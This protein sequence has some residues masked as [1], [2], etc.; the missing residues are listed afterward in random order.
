M[1]IDIGSSTTDFTLMNNLIVEDLPEFGKDFG[2][3]KIDEAIVEFIIDKSNNGEYFDE[4]SQKV[5]SQFGYLTLLCRKYKEK[6]FGKNVQI[7]VP[8]EDDLRVIYQKYSQILEKIDSEQI[9]GLSITDAGDTWGD[10]FRAL[11]V[12]V[13]N[14][15]IYEPD[16]VVVTGGGS[17]MPFVVDIVRDVFEASYIPDSTNFKFSDPSLT[18]TNGLA[19]YGRWQFNIIQFYRDVELFCESSDLDECIKAGLQPFTEALSKVYVENLHKE[20][21][22]PLLIELRDKKV[23]TSKIDDFRYFFLN[24]FTAWLDSDK[25]KISKD[26][27]NTAFQSTFNPLLEKHTSRIEK[28][29]NIP[30]GKFETHFYLTKEILSSEPGIERAVNV[31]IGKI[32]QFLDVYVPGWAR[33]MA[34]NQILK[35]WMMVEKWVFKNLTSVIL[36]ALDESYS[37]I[38]LNDKRKK[39]FIEVIKKEIKKQLFAKAASVEKY[40]E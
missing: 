7:E 26:K 36:K 30:E 6:S 13:K 12:D 28:S 27:I 14:H 35:I 39:I 34:S 23:D 21:L 8:E 1:V 9:K 16:V 32:L 24:R 18:I 2:C 5:D 37:V 20:V 19:R 29:N 3:R 40:L 38:G 33:G 10:Q 22:L 11:L 17:R 15:I 25:G 4:F 31:L